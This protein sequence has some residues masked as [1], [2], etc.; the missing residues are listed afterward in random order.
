MKVGDLV[1]WEYASNDEEHSVSEEH[2][3]VIEISRTGHTT[4]SA[5]V[6]FTDGD[7]S[8]FDTQRL[9]IVNES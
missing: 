6:L 7:I 1:K 8:W 5:K 3:I 2:G 9:V 4:F